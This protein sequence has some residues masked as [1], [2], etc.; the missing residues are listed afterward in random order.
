MRLNFSW[1]WFKISLTC[2]HFGNHCFRYQHWDETGIVPN[3]DDLLQ[4]IVQVLDLFN[5]N[6]LLANCSWFYNF[7]IHIHLNEIK[8]LKP[9]TCC[10]Y[11]T[12]SGISPQHWI[13]DTAR[14][15]I[16]FPFVFYCFENL[17]I[18]ITLEALIYFRWFSAKCTSPNE[19]FNQIKNWKCHMC[20]LR[21]I[22]PDRIKFDSFCLISSHQSAGITGTIK[23]LKQVKSHTC[24]N[25]FV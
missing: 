19:D 9:V 8:L 23:C 13:S 18:V 6:N 15:R 24:K 7:D 10:C 21:P 25:F 2:D 3:L 1:N 22:P 12:G 4:K 14:K 17:S 20:D 11:L 5:I 16:C